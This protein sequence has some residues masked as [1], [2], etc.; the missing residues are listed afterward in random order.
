[1]SWTAG[2]NLMYHRLN[3]KFLSISSQ[4]SRF[5]VAQIIF[6]FAITIGPF[7]SDTL[8]KVLFFLAIFCVDKS[9]IKESLRSLMGREKIIKNYTL[10]L[11]I[12][13]F[14]VTLVPVFCGIDPLG[15][16]IRSI[17]YPLEIMFWVVGTVIFAKDSFFI[18]YLAL[19]SLCASVF[20]SIIAVPHL[21]S[22]K[23][24]VDYSYYYAWPLSMASWSVGSILVCLFAWML[25]IILYKN[26]D[27]YRYMPL[28]ITLYLLVSTI[29]IS[30]LY[31][32]FWLIIC[33]QN[34]IIFFIL[35][36]FNKKYICSFYKKILCIVIICT[37]ALSAGI[38]ISPAIKAALSREFSQIMAVGQD[39]SRFTSKRNL[40]W[41]E[42]LVLIK[43]RLF[44]GY[45]WA[46]YEQYSNPPM[47]HTHS[48][49]LQIAW[50][51]GVFPVVLFAYILF[52]SF[53][54]SVS[55]LKNTQ[56]K[57]TLPTVLLLVL[58]AFTINGCLDNLFS[59]T[60]RVETLYWV[61]LSLPICCAF[62]KEI[63]EDDR[64]HNG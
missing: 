31:T 43:Q 21:I 48:S 63:D 15:E 39:I 4:V 51:A 53:Y 56:G 61:Y 45:G 59:A 22:T 3:E 23:F 5:Q 50:T 7:L 26:V 27:N 9:Q 20:Y 37:F 25:Y 19:A 33:V 38:Y 47:G 55:M 44:F 36:I 24:I 42:A 11:F 35:I 58:I 17:G 28:E 64:V 13:L 16:R 12:F 29:I 40:V 62:H 34:L 46:E 14:Y 18:R 10:S 54:L 32:T 57:A 1:M 30:T 60:R 52:Q 49:F 41:N 8:R 2:E 6:I